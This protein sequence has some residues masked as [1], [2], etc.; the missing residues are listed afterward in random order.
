MRP[1]TYAAQSPIEILS[2]E[3]LRCHMGYEHKYE[4]STG[5]LIKHFSF[6]KFE[7][8]W[9]VLLKLSHNLGAKLR[10][11]IKSQ[12]LKTTLG[13]SSKQMTA[14]IQ[15]SGETDKDQFKYTYIICCGNL[16]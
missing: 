14:R 16:S 9:R 3:L 1:C 4:A 15:A 8:T 13:F 12:R 7:T 6:V 10:D 2:H 5:T 11:D